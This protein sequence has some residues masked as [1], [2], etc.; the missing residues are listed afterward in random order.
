MSVSMAAS[1]WT[2][3]KV[4]FIGT[5]IHCP[6]TERH[7][8]AFRKLCAT[9]GI[10][11]NLDLGRRRHKKPNSGPESSRR[12]RH[13]HGGEAEVI[14]RGEARNRLLADGG[15]GPLLRY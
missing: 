7:Y 15:L 3:R 6:P 5:C 13:S 8:S 2:L 11:V 10:P 12:K 9:I 1:F 14:T 4:I